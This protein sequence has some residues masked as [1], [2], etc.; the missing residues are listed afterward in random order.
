MS[1]E[2][3]ITVIATGFSQARRP[4]FA[5]PMAQENQYHSLKDIKREMIQTR[6]EVE[7]DRSEFK[8]E[9]WEVNENSPQADLP[10]FLKKK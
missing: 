4:R 7:V 2:I 5:R 1:D 6:Q 3:K 9:N 8:R 10:E